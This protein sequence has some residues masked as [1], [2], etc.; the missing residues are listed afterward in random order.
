[1]F[2]ENFSLFFAVL[3]AAFIHAVWNSIVKKQEEKFLS[4]VFV[5]SVASLISIFFLPFF[6]MPS[7][8]S[9]FFLLLSLLFHFAY[10]VFLAES[11]R[12][13]DFSFA[14]PISRGI[15]PLLIAVL[16]FIFAGEALNFFE[17]LGVVIICLGIMSVAMTNK[18][19]AFVENR[20]SLI[21]SLLTGVFISCYTIVD[22]L[23]A[24]VSAC[25]FS[26][27]LWLF[28]FMSWPLLLFAIFRYS[29]EEMVESFKASWMTFVF[30]GGLC[31]L[32][33]AIVIWALSFHSMALVSALRETSVVIGSIIGVYILKEPFGYL[34]IAASIF[35]LLGFFVMRLVSLFDN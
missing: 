21:F 31:L 28:S 4:I 14:Y 2:L 32:A 35:V 9:F 30:G 27:A 17:I 15:A 3:F 34:R 25:P 7:L 26:Y 18:G 5:S 12:Y 23:G 16:S 22:G 13:G 33:Y 29:Q 8:E 11:Y 24:R 20:K 19:N 6:P 10:S 1:M